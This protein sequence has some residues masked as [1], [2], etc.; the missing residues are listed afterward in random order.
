MAVGTIGYLY[1]VVDFSTGDVFVNCAVIN[2]TATYSMSRFFQASQGGAVSALCLVVY[3][4]GGGDGFDG[5]AFIFERIASDGPYQTTYIDPGD[6]AHGWV[7]TF[8]AS[9]CTVMAF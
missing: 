9:D 8:A 1:Q 6:P 5:G 7:G 3:D 2:P 4:P